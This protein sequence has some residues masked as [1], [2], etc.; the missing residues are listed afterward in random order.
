[1]KKNTKVIAVANQKGGVGKTTTAVNIAAELRQR[2]NTVLVIDL[3]PQNS[4][5][6]TYLKDSSP[7]ATIAEIMTSVID[8][9]T[10]DYDS[11]IAHNELNDIDYI[12]ATI[13][14]TKVERQLVVTRHAET[15]LRKGLDKLTKD[16][17]YI[18][19]DCPPS[20]STLLYNAL[21]AADY[22]VV[23]VIAQVAALDGVPLLLDTIS[24]VQEN[25]NSELDILGYI[26]TVYE[27]QTKMSQ[28][29]KETLIEN[30]G[31]KFLGYI[32]KSTN[33]PASSADGLA[34]CKYKRNNTNKYYNKLSDEYSCIVDKLIERM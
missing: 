9:E 26:E 17:D 30:F 24:E 29:V 5:S 28:D 25:D 12:P 10:M 2:K 20:L 6:T 7:K 31:D 27:E 4:L 18:I 22:V 3:D 33:A 13:S 21:C 11:C 8:R 34:F 14:L 1:M 19:I 32:S 16:Y 23:P 15:V